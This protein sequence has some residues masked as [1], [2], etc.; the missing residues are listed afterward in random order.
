[1]EPEIT[2]M[3]HHTWILQGFET[4][5]HESQAGLELTVLVS[6]NCGLDTASG[7]L[8]GGPVEELP[9]SDWPVLP[10]VGSAIPMGSW[11]WALYES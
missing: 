10:T 3:S 9:R 4:E 5:T 2:G 1:M 6:L 11:S 8:K 7:P